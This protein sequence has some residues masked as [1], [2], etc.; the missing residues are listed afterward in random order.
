MPWDS[1]LPTNRQQLMLRFAARTR[2]AVV[3]APLSLLGSVAGRSAGRVR[4]RGWRRDGDVHVLQA[5]DWAPYPVA[6]HSLAISRLADASFRRYIKREWRRL[7]W[8]APVLW[9]YAADS[10]DLLGS[11]HERLTLYHCV[12]DYAASARYVGYRR[13]APYAPAKREETLVRAV[14][15]LVVTS[16]RLVERWS[17]YNPHTHLLPNVAD[18]ALFA[19]ALL[20][21]DEHPTLAHLPRPRV[22]YIGA[23]DAYKVDLALLKGL[24]ALCPDVQFVC[25]GPV[26]IGDNTRPRALPRAPNLTY[27]GPLPQAELPAVLRGCSASLIPYAL[28]DYTASVSPLKLFEYLAAGQP[29]VASPLPALLAEQPQGLFLA[30]PTPTSFAIHIRQALALAQDERR[31]ISRQAQVH[32]WARRVE[33]LEALILERLASKSTTAAALLAHGSGGV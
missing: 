26:G 16:P 19:Q 31:A 3:E 4:R 10:A 29:V 23:L 30:D 14:D 12:D 5:W 6:K 20:P 9:T 32:S 15:L 11:F 8:P 2:V 17:G 1:I 7:G 27:L 24:V 22:A 28:N 18:V 13:V 21:G 33:E 25:I